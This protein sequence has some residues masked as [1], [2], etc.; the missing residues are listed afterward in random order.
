MIALGL[1]AVVAPLQAQTYTFTNYASLYG[2]AGV[3]VSDDGTVHATAF[4]GNIVYRFSASG[5]ATAFAGGGSFGSTDGSG[6]SARFTNPRAVA[7]DRTGN[8][9]V[10]DTGNHTIRKITP[11]GVVTTFAGLAGARGWDDGTGS[12]AR[13][14][15]PQGIAVD[16]AGNVYVADTHARSIRKIT[17]AGV[18]TT[19]AGLGYV[20]GSRDGTG[21]QA[22]FNVPQ[23]IT[24]AANGDVYV[25]DTGNHIIR[26]ITPEGVVTTVAGLPESRGFSD[27]TAN[28]ARFDS[29]Q[30]LAVDAT[31]TLFVADTGNNLIRKI[32]PAGAVTT[33]GGL[34]GFASETP[35]VGSA[36]RF[37]QTRGIA[38]GTN[39]AVLVADF[40]SLKSGA[41]SHQLAITV[42]PQSQSAGAG[43]SVRFNVTAT[44]AAP[45]LYQWQKDGTPL[46]GATVAT[47]AISSVQAASTGSYTVTVMNPVGT[48]TSAGA[49]LTVLSPLA[50]DNFNNSQIITGSTGQISG[51]NNGATGEP[52]E[53]THQ[54]PFATAS[55][56]WYRW[57]APAH[58][59]A[60]FDLSPGGAV[61]AVYFGTSLSTLTRVALGSR[62]TFTAVPDTT[63]HIAIGSNS[64]STRGNLSVAWRM[65]AN[66]AFVHAQEL[67]GD[68]GQISGNNNGATGEP[69]EPVHISGTSA[70]STSVWYAWT[71]TQT[72]VAVLAA[73]NSPVS[74]AIA[75]YTGTALNALTKIISS[76][77]GPLAVF[78]ANAGT[79]YRIA[80]GS[81][82]YGTGPF[83]LTWR[84]Q[85]AP[86]IVGFFGGGTF[87][88]GANVTFSANVIS[89]LPVTFAWLR[90][91]AVLPAG[92]SS[93]LA[94]TGVQPSDTGT[95]AVEVNSIGGS[96]RVTVST[97]TV[98]VPPANDNFA[99]AQTIPALNGST[100]GSNTNATGEAGEPVHW[101][102]AGAASSVWFRWTPA[103]RG[104]AI[105]DTVGSNF[106][107]VLAVYTGASLASLTRL[108]QDDDRGGGRTSQVSFAAT[109]GTTYSIAV[110]GSTTSARGTLTLGWQLSPVLA[111]ATPPA[112]Q[113]VAIGG[114]A[115]FSVQATG[116]GVTYQWARNGVSIPGATQATL[117]VASVQAGSDASYTAT[118][119]N[120]S[121]SVTSAPATLA[122]AAPSATTLSI[123]RTRA[124][125]DLLWSIA[126]G[127]GELV[128]VGS[129]GV[130][131]SSS[132]HGATWTP[133]SSGSTG[134]LVAVT[135]GGGQFVIVG[136]AGLIL[137]SPDGR[138]WTRATSS[139]TTE[140]INNV[141]YADG[142]YVAIGEKGLALTSSDGRVWTPRSTPVTT[143][144][145]GLAY[146]EGIRHFAACG[147]AG[148][149]LYSPDGVTWS[150]LP[151]P[152]LSS[153]LQHTV[154]VDSYANFVAVG[155]GGKIV[156]VRRNALVLKDGQP[157]VTW[158]AEANPTS[159]TAHLVG[160]VQGAG[161]LFAAGEDGKIITATS[162]RGPWTTLAS[163]TTDLLLAG[164]FH[165]DTL[166]VVG[167]RETVLQS[168]RLF[169]SR[170]INI[171]TRGQVGTG[172]DLMISGFVITGP[173]PKPV[174]IRAAGPTLAASFGLTGTLTAPVLTLVDSE[175]RNVATNTGWTTA[176]NV[177]A[178]TSTAARV[179]AFPF[180]ANSADSAI[181]TTL[182]PGA[183][184][185]LVSGANNTTG[186]SI[187]EV[188]D[189]DPLSNEGSRAINISTRGV[190]GSGQNK[191]I[192]GFIIGGAAAR[193]VLI[194]AVGPGI[195]GAP[196]NVGGTLAEPQIELYNSRS[197]LH[198]TAGAW[199]LQSNADEIRGSAQAV[200]AFALPEGSKDSAMV[201][202]LLPGAWTVQVGGPGTTTGV[203]LVE[204]YA[205]P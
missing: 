84:T 96:H 168:E 83:T 120:S 121:G 200:S 186:L 98:V 67:V 184:T 133:R 105:V 16:T 79:T 90:N 197:L 65:V 140:R 154:A 205:L 74:T 95:Y 171:S 36:A 179:G 77:G 29:P 118:I 172:S 80:I 180:A 152:G 110:G 193:R 91:G 11:A 20:N 73:S 78:V 53:P 22:L 17:P 115:T 106:D 49:V 116:S 104:I 169:S 9:Y 86:V 183:Y 40:F 201:V 123:R 136:E 89:H 163:G 62:L 45:L 124:E 30:A 132:D 103:S 151:V 126:A 12:T 31:G 56:I 141:I 101:N 190:A 47:F 50:N 7:I 14:D 19:L 8:L 178:I 52:T 143:G 38:V 155:E 42:Q 35:G 167:H 165:Q 114:S 58:G 88:A 194:R 27:G 111:V 199:G 177:A 149:F 3:A 146:H 135:Y 159:T 137:T 108:A 144:L 139:G 2:A 150:Q 34:A 131:L 166:Y 59:T 41:P 82:S 60:I 51:N 160:L 69:G 18:V 94:L 164:I 162:D 191:M 119:T 117:T 15:T 21:L 63:Y 24:V 64:Q 142:K 196:F 129:F 100:T 202:T 72:G 57:T 181:L 55:S 66:D 13:F 43:S 5:V 188:Y 81:Y 175:N 26:K 203:V 10:A 85:Q 158:T 46:A 176:A 189:A 39:G 157:L 130:I 127:A 68:T 128:T 33:I 93:A 195:A 97:L 170:L 92:N 161:A 32:T 173:Q 6:T 25:T 71:P 107:T 122:V 37:N 187:V 87:A 102:A 1:G 198:A 75:V 153:A 113:I 28:T 156:S 54:S 4:Y 138:V 61:G 48:L 192:A 148:V 112:S 174:L 145:H 204:V 44:G 125:G 147:D 185:T 134:W 70:T 109:A 182:T 76:G 23:G 99:S